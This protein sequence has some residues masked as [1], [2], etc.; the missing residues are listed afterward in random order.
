MQLPFAELI[1]LALTVLVPLGVMVVI[2]LY[3][4]WQRTPK[5]MRWPRKKQSGRRAPERD[6]KPIN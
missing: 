6:V 5:D 1:H 3:I 4:L 2:V